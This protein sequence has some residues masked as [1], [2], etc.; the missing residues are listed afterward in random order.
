MALTIHSGDLAV[1]GEFSGVRPYVT[2][3]LPG[4]GD[5]RR[6]R[7]RSFRVRAFLRLIARE[8]R[9]RSGEGAGISPLGEE[10]FEATRFR[11]AGRAA[12]G[13][14]RAIA[15]YQA[16]LD[17]WSL[18]VM[19]GELVF[20]LAAVRATEDGAF[21][22]A[23]LEQKIALRRMHPLEG[24]LVSGARWNTATFRS[25]WA[26]PHAKKCAGCGATVADVS[27]ASG[28][29]GTQL[30]D[31]CIDDDEL[32]RIL[33]A[34]NSA[35]WVDPDHA[36]IHVPGQGLALNASTIAAGGVDLDLTTGDW[37][38]FRHLPHGD[39]SGLAQRAP[40]SRKMLAYVAI[41]SA[42][43][44]PLQRFPDVFP[45]ENDG[46]LIAAGPWD[47]LLRFALEL[48][49]GAPESRAAITLEPAAAHVDSAVAQ[50][51][52]RLQQT[53]AGRVWL[54]SES[55]DWPSAKDAVDRGF[56]MAQWLKEDRM[57]GSALRRIGE[58]HRLSNET[59]TDSQQWKLRS[60]PMLIWQARGADRLLRRRILRMAADPDLWR[61]TGLATELALLA[62]SPRESNARGARFGRATNGQG[63]PVEAG[64]E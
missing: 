12:E 45:I 37:P 34:S 15:F 23:A 56:E 47:Q 49:G 26:D 10:S 30:C 41:H 60:L 53:E 62:A 1:L 42:A 13:A 52:G 31:R 61:N 48:G 4:A 6:L 44:A 19:G 11:L 17:R 57:S 24:A 46:A 14:E 3:P 58:V 29:D 38:V 59:R 40:G 32:G 5:A 16:D 28:V 18:D 33:P 54:F 22:D 35:Q 50:V 55:L 7:A 64:V 21:P 43:E 39:F 20:H 8:I 27:G 9:Q 2:K 63:D 36:T 25:G 51:L